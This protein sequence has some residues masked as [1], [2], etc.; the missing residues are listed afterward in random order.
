[1]EFCASAPGKILWLGGYSVLEK[2]NVSL[3]TAI[4]K[5]VFAKA[6]K[7][8]G[9]AV[10]FILPQFKVKVEG[11]L[12]NGKIFLEGKGPFEKAKFVI[13]AANAC[14]RYLGANTLGF[15]LTTI[16]DKAFGQGKKTGLGSSA[17]VTVAAVSAILGLNGYNLTDDKA[18][19]LINN[20]SQFAHSVSQGK[21][22]SGFDV[23]SAVFGTIKYSRY[24]PKIL[25]GVSS[26]GDFYFKTQIQKNWDYSII[27]ISLPKNFIPVIASTNSPTSTTEMVRKINQYKETD[28]LYF[29]TME[30]IN[31]ANVQAI[32]NLGN[33][34]KFLKYFEDGRRLT[35]MLG[36][37]S[38]ADVEGPKYFALI[39]KSLSNGAYVCKLP[40]AGGG[41]SI[42]AICLSDKNAS[43]LANFW[44]KQGMDVL[45]VGFGKFGVK[46]ESLLAFNHAFKTNA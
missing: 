34:E 5:R 2:G 42:A 46:R 41:D 39:S 4:D 28:G 11:K 9:G 13:E 10:E 38:G 8:Q 7:L 15:R 29:E 19:I 12:I 36:D 21:V 24:S 1:M 26:N 32:Q 45:D 27:P 30:K 40:G 35:K 18:K 3:V 23:A 31:S 43:K 25:D 33:S 6:E 14:V 37:L 20:L 17:A 16:S 44:E 22:G